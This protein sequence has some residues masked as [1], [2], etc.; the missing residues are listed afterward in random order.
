M[1][2]QL[3]AGVLFAGWM[4]GSVS[5]QSTINSVNRFA[6][7]ANIGWLDCRA[8][9]VNGTVLGE[10]ICSGYIYA[11]NVGWINLGGGTAVNGIR[12]QNNSA[13]DFGVNHDGL[14]NLRGYAWGANI[15]WVNF[16][17][18]GAPRLDLCTGKLSGSVYGANVGWISLSNSVA[19]VQTDSLRR[20]VDTDGDGIPD[21]FELTWTGSLTNMNST[22]DL[23]GD[24][25]SDRNEY[26]AGTDPTNPADRL[27]VL[28]YF[29]GT[30]ALKWASK[31]SRH[32]HIE[33]R[34]SLNPSSPWVD[35]SLGL[36][37]HDPGATTTRSGFSAPS[38]QHFFRIEVV[39]PL[40]P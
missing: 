13:S 31:P 15:G 37:T 1:L 11:A 21:A 10:Y 14:G 16:E 9:G 28:S 7:G 39:R 35:S 12:Y 26:L 33:E 30:D 17:N 3:I 27:A 34:L 2:R 24:G 36:I 32:Y 8:D 19:F 20:G 29:V 25:V 40:V 6:Y 38:S 18:Q 5:A 4:A 23:D 22:S